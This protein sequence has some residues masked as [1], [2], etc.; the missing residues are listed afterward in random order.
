MHTLL[1]LNPEKGVS[2][3]SEKKSIEYDLNIVAH[4]TS[5]TTPK[6]LTEKNIPIPFQ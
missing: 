6:E 1:N 5:K 4:M 3:I 2:V